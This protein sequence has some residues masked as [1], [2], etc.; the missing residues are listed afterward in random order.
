MAQQEPN[1]DPRDSNVEEPGD[2]DAA[3]IVGPTGEEMPKQRHD[4]V[5]PPDGAQ[6]D[7]RG[8]ADENPGLGAGSDS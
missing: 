7:D 2:T 4:G 6:D 8:R 1:P 5:E 3:D